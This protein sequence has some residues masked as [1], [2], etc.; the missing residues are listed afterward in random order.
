[1][2]DRSA[3]DDLA[4]RSGVQNEE[5]RAKNRTLGN[6]LKQFVTRRFGAIDANRKGAR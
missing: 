4:E 1:V 2:I 5:E 6:T 3:R